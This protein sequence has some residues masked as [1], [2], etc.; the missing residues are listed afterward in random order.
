MSPLDGQWR[1]LEE[2]ARDP[3][4]LALAESE[5]P[6]LAEA[7]NAPQDR[8]RALKLIAASLALAGLGGCGDG[9]RADI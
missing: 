9:R 4:L 6:H 5:F 2:L 3:A 8:R 7:L 1:S